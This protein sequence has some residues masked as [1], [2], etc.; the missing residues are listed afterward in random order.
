MGLFSKDIG[1]DLGTANT[2]VFMKGKG[3]VMREPSVVAV[4]VRTDTVLAVG[5]AAKEMIGRTPGS[6]VAVRPLKDGVIADFDI[7]A[8]MLK[9]FIRQTVKPSIFSKP[10]VIVCI[11]SGVTD[12]E[13]RA[14]EDT[15]RQAGAG[16]V[17]LIEEPMAAAIGAGLP[18][19]EPTGSLVVD[20]GGGTSEVAMISLGDIVT[21]CSVRVAGDK[22]DE[23]I[24]QYVKKKYNLLIGERTAEEI[25]IKIGSAYPY[26][27]E[28]D[29]QI[30]GRNLV[31][32]LPKN[33]V[34]SAAEV[35]DALADPLSVIVEA[36]RS[37][38]EKTPP[39]L[40]ADIIDHGI[41]LTG[42]GALLR[43]LD[44]LVAQETN[45]P[46]HVAERPLDCVAEGT[47]KRLEMNI[48]GNFFMKKK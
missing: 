4:D 21:A 46:V 27:G 1:I 10:K 39:E 34:I 13:R 37:T 12:V 7:T 40:S 18:V 11:P 8:T 20:I 43:G 23:S 29:M 26:E 41:M 32:G 5:A 16:D 22:F 42:G 31:D 36:I 14:V 15:A 35:R 47:G 48:D 2:L 33:V 6:I 25:K 38:L 9:H 19:F 44:F 45:M 17:K 30:K 3:I 28:G 24:I